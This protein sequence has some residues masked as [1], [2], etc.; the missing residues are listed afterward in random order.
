VLDRDEAC[1]PHAAFDEGTFDDRDVAL[2]SCAP[3]SP[4]REAL[5]VG[6]RFT[7]LEYWPSIQPWQSASSNASW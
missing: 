6:Q 4:R 3:G 5:A 7:P 1:G 2:W